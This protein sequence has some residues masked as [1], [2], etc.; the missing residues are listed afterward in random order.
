[1][2]FWYILAIGMGIGVAIMWMLQKRISYIGVQAQ[3][4]LG[5]G[6]GGLLAAGVAALGLGTEHPRSGR[7]ISYDEL[8]KSSI[9]LSV[10]PLIAGLILLFLNWRHRKSDKAKQAKLATTKPSI[11]NDSPDSDQP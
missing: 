10:F 4:W 9:F 2:A 3:N 8:A 7:W 6:I 1:M 11:T 5:I